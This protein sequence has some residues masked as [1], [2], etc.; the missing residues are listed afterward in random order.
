MKG[1][2]DITLFTVGNSGQN[3]AFPQEVLQNWKL[4]GQKTRSLETPHDFF[5]ITILFFFNR[6]LEILLGYFF[7]TPN[8]FSNKPLLLFRL[9]YCDR[10]ELI[11][12]Q[13]LNG[14]FLSIY[15]FLCWKTFSHIVLVCSVWEW[16]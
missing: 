11:Y 16:E 14:L 15:Q 1:L 12:L 5:L 13:I 10:Y 6:P 9:Y 7:D 3:K 4:P 2:E 8:N